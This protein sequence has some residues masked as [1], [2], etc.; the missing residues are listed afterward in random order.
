MTMTY[1][2]RGKAGKVVIFLNIG[3]WQPRNLKPK[4]YYSGFEFAHRECTDIE[5]ADFANLKR[6][7]CARYTSWQEIID[8][9]RNC[10]VPEEFIA[11][12]KKFAASHPLPGDEKMT[13]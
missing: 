8:D 10:G 9:D 6:L 5:K 11:K 2:Y 3:E 4:G 13:L 12:I 1:I 7:W